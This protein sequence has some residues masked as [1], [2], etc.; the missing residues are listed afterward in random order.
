PSS[1]QSLVHA[2]I[3]PF[4]PIFSN[5][6]STSSVFNFGRPSPINFSGVPRIPFDIPQSSSLSLGSTSRPVISGSHDVS[7]STSTQPSLT[8]PKRRERTMLPCS[9]CG[10]TFDRPSLLKRHIRT[11]TGEKPHVC[12]V[13]GKGFSTSSSL[14]TH[15]RI[16]SGEKPH[17]CMICG[18]RFTASSNLYY[19]KMTHVKDKPHKC[20]LCTR[21]FPT[22]GDLRSHMFVHNGQW[23]H[24][25]HICG[26]GFSKITNLR[27]HSVLHS[28]IKHHERTG[29][30]S[31]ESPIQG[32][33]DLRTSTAFTSSVPTYS[34]TPI[35]SSEFR[36]PTGYANN[37]NLS[38]SLSLTPVSP[39]TPQIMTAINTQ[40]LNSKSK[41]QV[42]SSLS[43]IN[44]ISSKPSISNI[45]TPATLA[46]I[47]SLSPKS[48]TPPLSPEDQPSKS[49]IIPSPS[50]PH[51]TTEPEDNDRP[52]SKAKKIKLT[53]DKEEDSLLTET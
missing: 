42:C 36:L 45:T 43:I 18:K 35:S 47:P 2:G 21:S 25:C 41:S 14:N 44:L 38:N 5:S 40:N 28:E 32:S 29:P 52:E 30:L 6:L 46:D 9:D 15:R 26:K 48:A 34:N 20:S 51:I 16:H 37:T 39:K 1:I 22:P 27:N 50:D 17:Q 8:P 49:S 19:H 12:D 13:C 4:S 7:S 53:E 3:A 10:K 11:H 33:I 23:P 24:K 31:N